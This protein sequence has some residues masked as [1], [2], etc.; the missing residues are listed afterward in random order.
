MKKILPLTLICILLLSM[1]CSTQESNAS[2]NMQP[3]TAKDP[4]EF[5]TYENSEYG[6]QIDYPSSWGKTEPDDVIVAFMSQGESTSQANL[7][8]VMND[9]SEQ[10][11]E[12]KE[13]TQLVLEQLKQTFPDIEILKS[14]STVLANIPAY[15][16]I[17]TTSNVKVMQIWTIK[18]KI[19]YIWTYTTKEE[20]FEEHQRTIEAMLDSFEITK[21]IRDP[22][23]SEA[24]SVSDADTGLVGS[25]RV[26]SERIFYDIGGAGSMATPVTRTLELA[27]DGTWKFGDSKG[28][29]TVTEIITDDWSRWDVDSYGPTRK[30]TFENWN[31]ASADGPIEEAN[32]AVDFIW[33]IYHVEPP[34]VENS[35]TVWLKFGKN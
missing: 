5:L 12:L 26:F 16:V 24:P 25:W 18:H 11:L 2:A 22:S 7:N 29:W 35:G 4:S 27:K 17:Y 34:L 30:V 31:E 33:V 14:R 21:N 6:I 1:G 20:E 13:Y 10:N 28:T 23:D 32:G 8:L 3:Q 15:Q 19:S 9:L